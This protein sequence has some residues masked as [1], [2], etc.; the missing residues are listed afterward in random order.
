M[1]TKEH[2]I[3]G[4]MKTFEQ[5]LTEKSGCTCSCEPCQDGNCAGCTCEDC[6]CDG[7]GCH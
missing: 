6:D 7:C 4:Y 2:T 5:F 1:L 3:G